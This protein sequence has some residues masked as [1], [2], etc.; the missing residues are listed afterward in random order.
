[1]P[2]LMSVM[3]MLRK[4]PKTPAPCPFCGASAVR[5]WAETNSGKEHFFIE[6]SE[7]HCWWCGAKQEVFPLCKRDTKIMRFWTQQ[8]Q[9]SGRKPSEP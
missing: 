1:M 7:P 6:Y 3:A 5:G 2:L 8:S 4:Y 9:K